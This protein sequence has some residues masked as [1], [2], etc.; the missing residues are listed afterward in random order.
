MYIV[1][2]RKMNV[3]KNRFNS[4]K[5]ILKFNCVDGEIYVL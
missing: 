2:E 1:Y 3:S 5:Y 4:I